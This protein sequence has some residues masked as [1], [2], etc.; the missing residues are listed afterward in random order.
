MLGL[1]IDHR[2]NVTSR[3]HYPSTHGGLALHGAERRPNLWDGCNRSNGA[4]HVA[5]LKL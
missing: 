4:L 5:T 3:E 2:P 1:R